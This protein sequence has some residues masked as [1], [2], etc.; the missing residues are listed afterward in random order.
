MSEKN[1]L[2]GA[3]FSDCFSAYTGETLKDPGKEGNSFVR[4][5]SGSEAII[6]PIVLK[7]VE[8]DHKVWMILCNFVILIIREYNIRQASPKRE[9]EQEW[10]NII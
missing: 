7:M 4:K 1:Y 3:K 8:F 9:L 10:R 6:I 2:A 5:K